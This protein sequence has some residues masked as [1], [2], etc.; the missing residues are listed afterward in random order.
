M[1]N[2]DTRHHPTW[3]LAAIR[4][5]WMGAL[6]AACLLAGCGGGSDDTA[7]PPPPP[8]RPA[9][10][11][12]TAVIGPAGGT[13]T[14]ADGVQVVIPPGALRVD[15]PIGIT[16]HADDAPAMDAEQ[17]RPATVYAFTPHDIAFDLP[18]TVRMPVPT[19]TETPRA[20]FAS[21][22]LDWSAQDDAVD[23]GFLVVQRMR[24]SWGG[25]TT[26]GMACSGSANGNR[27]WCYTPWGGSV[28]S[29]AP[30]GA[31]TRIAYANAQGNTGGSFRLDAAASVSISSTYVLWPTC[32]HARVRLL[33]RAMDATPSVVNTLHDFSVALV[34]GAHPWS[35]RGAAGTV[36]FPAIQMSH[37][38]TGRH[39]YGVR[40]SCTRA[41]GQ[42][43]E[44]GDSLV[45]DVAVPVPTVFHTVGGSVSG[46]AGSGL[47]LRNNG[48]DDLAV[49]ADGS[50]RFAT[51]VGAGTPYVV[52]VASAPAGQSCTVTNGN[53]TATADVGN[54]SVTCTTG[55]A[56]QLWRPPQQWTTPASGGVSAPQVAV[57]AS[58]AAV[59][60]W[61]QDTGLWARQYTPGS[62][63]G[64]V[65][66]VD[67][68]SGNNPQEARV[69]ID[70]AGNVMAIWAQNDENTSLIRR[71]IWANHF[72][73]GAWSGA[74]QIDTGTEHAEHPDLGTDAIGN[75]IAVWSE[76]A[77]SSARILTRRFLLGDG[78]AG[79]S[80]TIDGGI[81]RAIAPRIAVAGNGTA[82][83]VWTQ[84]DGTAYRILAN[85]F[86]GAGWSTA[87]IVDG[88]NAA[89]HDMPQLA[90]DAAG[91]AV[92]VWMQRVGGMP[93]LAARRYSPSNGWAGPAVRVDTGAAQPLDHR[94]T[95]NAQ[96]QA[97]LLWQ[98]GANDITSV[99]AR[100][101]LPGSGW[102]ASPVRLDTGLP[103]TDAMNSLCLASDPAGNAIA[104]WTYKGSGGWRD[105]YLNRF[106]AGGNWSAPALMETDDSSGLGVGQ[107]GL[108]MDASGNTIAGWNQ[109]DGGEVSRMWVREFR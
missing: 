102:V 55:A 64:G 81:G 56:G 42:T 103:I 41:D 43:R 60:L 92:L 7:T 9:P 21:N 19:T 4:R 37:L 77:G 80:Q 51:P 25:W 95:L 105:L 24:F 50:F 63:W 89:E 33:H 84:Y 100:H 16:T 78:W 39:A 23:A 97:V 52:T 28:P 1:R 11:T 53:G 87:D 44:Y 31:L 30:A 48:G 67:N 17:P 54:V 72:H 83:A 86:N 34:V 101:D 49:A 104:L 20:V 94:V 70:A 66:R 5:W 58:G 12:V 36:T 96:G 90:G 14:G 57:N 93:Q 68:A 8:S 47:V 107:C 108:G 71:A 40:V 61:G 18:V 15:T 79:G 22:G 76:Q 82:T 69:A 29:A 98:E 6:L 65:T 38:D 45:I 74:R 26:T 73:S 62:G 99:W 35:T 59:L 91:N 2:A 109:Y 88:N 75:V 32:T 106:T 10:Q 27:D 85:R 13:V 3:H 46:L